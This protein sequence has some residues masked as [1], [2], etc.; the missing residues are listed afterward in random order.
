MFRLLRSI[1]ARLFNKHDP[2]RPRRRYDGGHMYSK[3]WRNDPDAPVREPRRHGPGGGR[4]SGVA[5]AEPEP[6][7]F[8]DL[9]AARTGRAKG[10]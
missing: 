1:I 8:I 5:V 2:A 7:Q 4:S 10:D 3:G 6:D 9:R